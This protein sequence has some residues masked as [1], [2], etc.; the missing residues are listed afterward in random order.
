[1]VDIDR[2]QFR[3]DI[4]SVP[5]SVFLLCLALLTV[6]FIQPSGLLEVG[7]YGAAVVMY[8]VTVVASLLLLRLQFTDWKPPE[9]EL[10]MLRLLLAVGLSF[11]LVL[12][13]LPAVSE[14]QWQ[15][16]LG[17][18]LMFGAILIIMMLL[19]FSCLCLYSSW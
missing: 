9:S 10:E 12:L 3:F 7:A 6:S 5:I 4:A 14:P 17:L 11:P 2:W 8:V 18:P 13:N 16:V 15:L 1:M 19:L